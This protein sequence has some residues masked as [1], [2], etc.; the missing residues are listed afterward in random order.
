MSTKDWILL[1][2]PILCNGI[3]VFLLQ[4][5]FEKRQL[6]LTEKYK[7]VS[8]MQQK[9]DNSLSLFMKVLQTSDD[10][11][12]QINWLNQFIASYCDVF[13]YYQQ[14][15]L[16]FKSLDNHMNKLIKKHEQIKSIQSKGDNDKNIPNTGIL[17]ESLFREIYELLQEIQ[18]DCLQRKV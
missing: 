8:I 9:V 2:V 12:V 18:N 1:L 3:V 15:K 14:N 16:I 5:A 11:L 7:Y 6:A 17:M 10:D 13:Y 4:K